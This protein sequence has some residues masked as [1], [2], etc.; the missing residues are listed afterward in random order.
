MVQLSFADR[1]M[2]MSRQLAVVGLVAVLVSGCSA[3]RLP[4]YNLSNSQEEAASVHVAVQSVQ[5]WNE[6]KLS[7][8]TNF[9][10]SESEALAQ[11]LPTTSLLEQDDAQRVLGALGVSLPGVSVTKTTNFVDDHLIDGV[12]TDNFSRSTTTSRADAVEPTPSAAT[13]TGGKIPDAM[14]TLQSDPFI[15]AQ[16]ARNLI[17]YYALLNQEID[18]VLL[19]YGAR[20]YLVRL[21][22]TVAPNKRRQPY[23]VTI[24]ISTFQTP[25]GAKVAREAAQGFRSSIGGPQLLPLVITDQV[26]RSLQNQAELITTQLALSAQGTI[27]G[28]GAKGSTGYASE[29]MR[30]AL[31]AQYNSLYSL[32]QLNQNTLRVRFGAQSMGGVYETVT[33]NHLVTFLMIVPD[34]VAQND[35]W[36]ARQFELVTRAYLNDARSGKRMPLASEQ[37]GIR[38]TGV[39]FSHFYDAYP[40]FSL[41]CV[42]PVA[43]QYQNNSQPFSGCVD[44]RL[45]GELTESALYAIHN[46]KAEYRFNARRIA[47]LSRL[48]QAGDYDAFVQTVKDSYLVE[49]VAGKDDCTLPAK[50][51]ETALPDGQFECLATPLV[52][53]EGGLDRPVN[54]V[55]AKTLYM[56]LQRLRGTPRLTSPL[57]L[58][59]IAP[60]EYPTDQTAF[61]AYDDKVSQLSLYGGHGLDKRRLSG[62][63]IVQA[64]SKTFK[65]PT[66]SANF[67]GRKVDLTF[68]PLT[69]IGEDEAEGKITKTDLCLRSADLENNRATVAPCPDEASRDGR[70]RTYEVVLPRKKR[71]LPELGIL[72]TTSDSLTA[73]AGVAELHLQVV[74]KA[75]STEGLLTVSNATIK[76]ATGGGEVKGLGRKFVF[77][78]ANAQSPSIVTLE[79]ENLKPDADV[80]L[81]LSP[82]EGVTT[83]AP[84]KKTLKVA[85][86]PK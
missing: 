28:A 38:S 50:A 71:V 64:G 4:T 53:A 6:A 15:Q 65:L 18:N 22:V 20:A 29:H 76:S 68:P 21:Q 56:E 23:D 77:A 67:D 25:E 33:R 69:V 66:T 34:D 27:G 86:A 32:A 47:A 14:R 57:T 36:K 80:V 54:T 37:D 31:S 52:A 72:T 81:T 84:A 43:Q 9:K 3:T 62:L 44:N 74:L 85:T 82:A 35:A 48:A 78:A 10:L 12:Q 13:R 30:N 7:L 2:A 8:S 70:F 61:L 63:L 83:V 42:V 19:P 60:A 49:I 73:V 75:G 55:R 26:E 39:E 58:P 41:N 1:G 5:D 24:D 79:L 11:A 17:H 46:N 59:R 51:A 16:T 45:V 40:D